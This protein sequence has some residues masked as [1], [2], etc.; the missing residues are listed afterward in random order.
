VTSAPPPNR[1]VEDDGFANCGGTL[2]LIAIFAAFCLAITF[3]NAGGPAAWGCVGL[4]LTALIAALFARLSGEVKESFGARV[5]SIAFS[6]TSHMARWT[7]AGLGIVW[8]LEIIIPA[9]HTD[10]NDVAGAEAHILDV[11]SRLR[12]AFAWPLVALV[13]F[14]CLGLAAWARSAAPLV[15]VGRMRAAASVVLTV[16]AGLTTFTF[17]VEGDGVLR[18]DHVAE[19]ILAELRTDASAVV[20]HR[21]RVAAYRWARA[22]LQRMPAEDRRLLVDDLAGVTA[23]RAQAACAALAQAGAV[24][25]RLPCDPLNVQRDAPRAVV[26]N[27][28]TLRQAEVPP[29]LPW[30]PDFT[31]ELEVGNVD[32]SDAQTTSLQTRDV[33]LQD[34]RRRANRIRAAAAAVQG[35]AVLCGTAA[36]GAGEAMRAIAGEGAI[37]DTAALL[38]S[39]IVE[40]IGEEDRLKLVRWFVR[41]GDEIQ[42]ALSVRLRTVRQALSINRRASPADVA[43][44]LVADTI[45]SG[46]RSTRELTELVR[47]NADYRR[48]HPSVRD[49]V[50]RGPRETSPPERP[51]RPGIP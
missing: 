31:N 13:V 17:V 29:A 3:I 4:G 38:V 45:V 6:N 16:L 28:R 41:A 26:E 9:F 19:T 36:D 15:A 39:A 47:R 43:D 40:S 34:L 33:A 37:S 27:G 10:P 8:L 14:F 11:A 32:L 2:A 12:N 22:Q 44:A 48:T 7:A 18:H 20:L 46:S 50:G 24:A 25:I 49:Y 21:E 51:R 5:W 23:A 42:P 1:S 30:L 35:C